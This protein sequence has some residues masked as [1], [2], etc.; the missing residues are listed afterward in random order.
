MLWKQLNPGYQVLMRRGLQGE[1]VI[2]HAEADRPNSRSGLGG[3]YGWSVTVRVKFDDGSS[4]DYKRY[5]D[6]T[7]APTTLDA[8]MILPI[9]FDANKRSRVEIDTAAL[10]SQGATLRSEQSAQAEATDAAAVQRA[11]QD[12]KPLDSDRPPPSE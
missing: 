12:L 8:G 4:A 3:V 5:V 7:V 9:R 2:V 1:A 6:A 11:E 10:R